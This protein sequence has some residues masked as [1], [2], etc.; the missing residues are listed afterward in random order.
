MTMYLEIGAVRIQQWLL[1]TPELR[2]MRGASLLLSAT[3]DN[4]SVIEWLKETYPEPGP[5]TTSEVGN[6]DG[7]LS[8]EIPENYPPREVAERIIEHL[9]DNAPAV[10]W[11]AWWAEAD[12][13][14]QAKI[15][16]K[17]GENDG[18]L[19][20]SPPTY[21]T[22]LVEQ[23]ACRREPSAPA[24]RKEGESDEDFARRRLGPD[25]AARDRA[26]S[27]R[28][29]E[30]RGHWQ[31]RRYEFADIPGEWPETFEN[32]AAEGGLE[33]EQPAPEAI[34]RK[35]SRNHLATIVADGNA[36]GAF[37]QLIANAPTEIDVSNLNAQAANALDDA[38]RAALRAAAKQAS[39]ENP[40]T[41]IVIPHFIGGDDLFLSVPAVEAWRFAAVLA[42]TYTAKSAD[43]L[44][45]VPK[46]E[47]YAGRLRD[48]ISALSL[49]IGICFAHASH[50]IAESHAAAE[51]ALHMAKRARGAG[52]SLG[53]IDLTYGSVNQIYCVEAE[54]VSNEIADPGLR[55]DVFRLDASARS[56]LASLI[57]D[58]SGPQVV[59]E[60]EITWW[61]QRIGWNRGP[62]PT[63]LHELPALLSRCRWFPVDTAGEQCREAS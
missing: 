10:E 50:P 23:C 58:S 14:T 33:L 47:P 30:E 34:G 16:D 41:K 45:Y 12:S 40:S 21:D 53:W 36:V 44:E 18:F 52:A 9:S 57:R 3:T 26:H 29:H 15:S 2:L 20:W 13:F 32:L 61:G 7:N 62:R 17:S 54:A 28:R 31:M 25:C 11:E 46:G 48:A 6:I 38:N 55:P 1:R 27:E 51:R 37:F 60:E 63:P 24:S 5:M 19:R 8:L 56:Q 22:T 39:A 49:G 59:T 4:E 35:N 43:L 42:K